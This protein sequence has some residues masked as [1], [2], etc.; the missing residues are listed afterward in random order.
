MSDPILCEVLDS[1]GTID[2]HEKKNVFSAK[3]LDVWK[4]P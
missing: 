2:N 1:I 4:C 3:K